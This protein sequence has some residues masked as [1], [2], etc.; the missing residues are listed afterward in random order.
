LSFYHNKI[1]DQGLI[2]LS[3]VIVQGALAQDSEVSLG[4]TLASAAGTKTLKHAARAR[5]MTFVSL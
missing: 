1:G 3:E 2:A 5:G 4:K